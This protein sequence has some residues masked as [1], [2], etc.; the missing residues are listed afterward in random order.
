M[1]TERAAELT[2][3]CHNY[4]KALV[5][6][7]YEAQ[8]GHPGGS[9]SCVEML[10]VLYHQE[11]RID[12]Q[13]PKMEGR[14]RLIL[15]KGHAAPILYLILAQLGYFSKDE[16]NK[17]RQLNAMLQG[18][19]CAYK[20]PGVE[21]STGPLG[22]GLGAGVGM[23]LGEQLKGSN[24]Y[25]YVVLGDGEIQEGVIW[26]A[27]LAAA[28]FN[29][30]H[31]IALLDKNGVQLDGRVDEIMPIED[32]A[33]K[34]EAFG[35]NPISCNGHDVE[36]LESALHKAKQETTKPSIL[37]CHT[38][39]GK[40]ISFMEGKNTWH[41]QTISSKAFALAMAELEGCDHE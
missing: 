29:T 36:A 8:T 31:C 33:A 38:V 39:K 26:E 23:A 2:A 32:V 27:A 11:M 14:D 41:G 25:I 12:P 9:L 7:L 22:L 3:L 1:T 21:L 28:K 24:A 13:H 5:A 6:L 20:T 17:L 37:L 16:L 30:C 34:W 18:H 35:W 10:T 19:P 40:G 4:R 15:S